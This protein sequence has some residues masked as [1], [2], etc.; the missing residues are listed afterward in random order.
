M[1]PI[2][3]PIITDEE[4]QKVIEVLKSGQLAQGKY[5]NELERTFAEYIGVDYAVAVCN[6][7][8]ALILALEALKIKSG[9]EVIT[10]PFTFIATANSILH[11]NARPVF[12]DIDEKTYNIDP[13][14]VAEKVTKKTRA[15]IGVHL[16]GHPF[17]VKD[18]LEICE[19]YGLVLIEDCAQAHG[20]EFEGKKVGSFGIGCFSFYPTKNITTGEGG[21]ITTNDK[22]IAEKIK[23]LRNHGEVSKYKHIELGYNYRMSELQGALGVVQLKRLDEMVKARRRNA[24][25]LNKH[26]KNSG[27]VKPF[28][29]RNVKH[30]YNQYVIRVTDEFPMHRDEL[31]RYLREKKIECAVHYPKPIYK[32]PIYIKMGYEN[33]RCPVAERICKE[34]LS[35]PVHP[36]LTVENL[37]YIVEVINKIK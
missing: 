32:Q 15:I 8:T 26:I 12:A 1:I 25:Y 6:G 31:V 27:L 2:S 22:K 5:V 23:L 17:K 33:V 34:V 3:K 28:E 35:L 10:T 20:A 4:I 11:Q 16:F 36:S 29:E 19:D 13:D 37:Q 24:K 21:I 9:D 14:D 30:A 18:L 7:T